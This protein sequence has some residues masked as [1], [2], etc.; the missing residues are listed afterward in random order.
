MIGVGGA[1]IRMPFRERV[2]IP[3]WEKENQRLKSTLVTGNVSFLGGTSAGD[4]SLDDG[5]R[6][7]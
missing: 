7:F 1:Q 4:G 5:K 2:H 3:P 6:E